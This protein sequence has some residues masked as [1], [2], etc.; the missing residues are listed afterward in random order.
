MGR[1][2]A[3]LR[4]AGRPPQRRQRKDDVPHAFA[5]RMRALPLAAALVAALLLPGC[6]SRDGGDGDG[7]DSG[8]PSSGPAPFTLRS[9]SFTNGSAIPARH[10]CDAAAPTSPPLVASGAP[11]GTESLALIVRDP[12]VPTPQAPTRT[13][14]HWV[15]WNVSVGAA[16]F[17]EGGVPVGAHEGSNDFGQGWLGP[18]PPPTSP[19]H[20][21]NLTAYALDARPAV[22]ENATAE[23]LEAAMEGHV[24]ARTSLIGLYA[25]QAV[26]TTSASPT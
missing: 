2:Q 18:C 16:V 9:A 22:P 13:I 4:L 3:A 5:G 24:L 11:E 23:Q 8:T 25:R 14:V 26:V 17:P 6:S 12:D 19:P 21:Y 20:R 7:G 1:V 10:T 15:V